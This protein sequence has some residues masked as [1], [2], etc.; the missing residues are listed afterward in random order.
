MCLA[1]IVVYSF[2]GDRPHHYCIITQIVFF[3]NKQA[4]IE[5]FSTFE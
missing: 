5:H 2:V 1:L 3:L 4:I